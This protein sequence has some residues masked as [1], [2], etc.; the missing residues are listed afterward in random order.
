MLKGSNHSLRSGRSGRRYTSDDDDNFSDFDG[1]A[2]FASGYGG[3]A[4]TAGM[5]R[6][7]RS[8]EN[9]D[10]NRLGRKETK[11]LLYTKSLVV[12]VLFLSTMLV[13]F[14]MYYITRQSEMVQFQ[15]DFIDQAIRI[16]EE[17]SLNYLHT[18]GAVDNLGVTITSHVSSM[19]LQWPYA[20][21]PEFDIRGDSTNSLAKS[22]FLGFYPLVKESERAQY[23]AYSESLSFWI[24]QAIA[25][26]YGLPVPESPIVHNHRVLQVAGG[27][28]TMVE[29]FVEGEGDDMEM[30]HSNMDHSNEMDH[31]NMD[32]SNMDADMDHSDHMMGNSGEMDHS[33]H[34]GHTMMNH[35]MDLPSAADMSPYIFEIDSMDGSNHVPAMGS[36]DNSTNYFPLFECTPVLPNAVNFNL[37]SHPQYGDE[38]RLV[39]RTND[40]VVGKVLQ[41][42]SDTMRSH[43]Q[44]ESMDHSDHAEAMDNSDHGG[45]DHSNHDMTGGDTSANDGMDMN[46]EHHRKLVHPDKD[47]F[48]SFLMDMAM[49]R[50]GEMPSQILF[51][52]FNQFSGEGRE[53]SGMLG[54]F[55]Y[56]SDFFADNLPDQVRNV[57]GVL[58]NTCGNQVFSFEINANQKAIYLGAGDFHDREFDYMEE[59]VSFNDFV[60]ENTKNGTSLTYSGVT[61]N[62]EHCPFTLRVYPSATMRDQTLTNKPII[63]TILVASAFLFTAVVLGLYDCIVEKRNRIILDNA[64]ASSLVLSSLFPQIVRDRMFADPKSSKSYLTAKHRLRTMLQDSK[65]NDQDM[66]SRPIADLFT[67]CTVLFAGKFSCFVCVCVCVCVLRRSLRSK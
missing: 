31:S 10:A 43:Y 36:T 61:V 30:D 53:L 23:E 37:L 19:N 4:S 64:K 45:M 44:H 56:W 13:S 47:P 21:V 58:E 66:A 40:I 50:D 25:R 20:F 8:S 51:P 49:E 48:E 14:A 32:H 46:H 17:F 38:A 39:L 22:E 67:D 41:Y 2:S 1:N 62:D 35:N 11:Q 16:N 7:S 52:V 65:K 6:T 12:F 24:D 28:M 34:D 29:E 63:Y 9:G 60:V 18:L 26:K 54:V 27:E 59:S 55:V 42:D 15:L 33:N 3:G 5:T 57:V